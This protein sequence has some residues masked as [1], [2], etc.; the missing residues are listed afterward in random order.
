VTGEQGAQSKV[1]PTHWQY[2]KYRDGSHGCRLGSG[3]GERV[4]WLLLLTS[5]TTLSWWSLKNLRERGSL[6]L[7]SAQPRDNTKVGS[8]KDLHTELEST[9]NAHRVVQLLHWTL[10][11]CLYLLVC[12][13]LVLLPWKCGWHLQ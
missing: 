12:W 4:W 8:L 11:Y 10:E 2:D 6:M 3:Q 5:E 7:S 1:M 13:E 9:V